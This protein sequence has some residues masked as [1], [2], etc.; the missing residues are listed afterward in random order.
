MSHV[1]EVLDFAQAR[2]EVLEFLKAHVL[3]E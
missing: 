3:G 1:H 2:A